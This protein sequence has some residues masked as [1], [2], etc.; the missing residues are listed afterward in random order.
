MADEHQQVIREYIR[1]CEAVLEL[2][3]LSEEEEST[4]GEMLVRLSDKL[5]PD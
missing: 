3:D 1:A 5:Y 2:R 4:V